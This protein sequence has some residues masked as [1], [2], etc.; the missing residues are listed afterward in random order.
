MKFKL[1][2]IT[3]LKS[4]DGF[5]SIYIMVSIK[6]RFPFKLKKNL[7]LENFV[8]YRLLFLLSFLSEFRFTFFFFVEF[9]NFILFNV[10]TTIIYLAEIN[11]YL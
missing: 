9:K 11:T 3:F 6:L 2:L 4:H 5:K 7:E 10:I 1:V 8:H